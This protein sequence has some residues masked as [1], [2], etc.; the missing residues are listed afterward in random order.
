MGHLPVGPG[1]ARRGLGAT[2]GTGYGWRRAKGDLSVRML[3][4]RPPSQISGAHLGPGTLLWEAALCSQDQ[5]K[6]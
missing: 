6:P 3:G 1:R 4:Q 5:G 2:S